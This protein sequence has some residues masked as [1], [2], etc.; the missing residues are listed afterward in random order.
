[1]GEVKKPADSRIYLG[2]GVV[3]ESQISMDYAKLAIRTVLAELAETMNRK[4][5]KV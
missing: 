1:M 5:R 3:H 4:E 2:G